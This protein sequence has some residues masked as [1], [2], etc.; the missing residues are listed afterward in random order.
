MA[1]TPYAVFTA[2]AK[3]NSSKWLDILP[4]QQIKVYWDNHTEGFYCDAPKYGMSRSYQVSEASD[5]VRK[6]LGEHGYYMIKTIRVD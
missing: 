5:A 2:T 6:F 4:T 1:G 3:H